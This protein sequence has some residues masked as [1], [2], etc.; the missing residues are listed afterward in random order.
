[1]FGSA[2]FSIRVEGKL[3]A[4]WSDYLCT[5]SMSVQEDEAGRCSTILI[6][7]PVDQAALIGL[8]VHLNGLGLPLASV[9]CLPVAPEQGDTPWKS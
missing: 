8:I 1:M 2:V 3:S 4:S 9:E 5:E 7:E 6:T